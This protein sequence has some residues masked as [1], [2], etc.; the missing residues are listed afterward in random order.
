MRPQ[1]L[2]E[3]ILLHAIG[4]L[5]GDEL[6]ELRHALASGDSDALRYA[7]TWN[8]VVTLFAEG[9]QPLDPP[10]EVKQN[11]LRKIQEHHAEQRAKEGP[12]SWRLEH[13]NGVYSVYPERMEWLKHPVPGVSFKVLSESEKRGYVTMLMKV[14][15]GTIFPAHHHSGEEECYILS[16][17]IIVNGRRLGTGVLHHGDEGSDHAALTTDEGALLL[18]VVARED[19]VP[20]AGV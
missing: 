11:L 9:L 6:K 1:R 2:E 7:T 16:G 12:G 5:D 17:S 8:E 13:A 19:Y 20:P 18:L 10:S 3:L 14:E 4:A 15:P